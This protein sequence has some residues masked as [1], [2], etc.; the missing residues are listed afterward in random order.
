MLIKIG[1]KRLTGKRIT[2]F[3][4]AIDLRSPAGSGIKQV[5]IDYRDG[6]RPVT[7]PA[8]R[9]IFSHNFARKGTYSVRISATDGAGNAVVGYRKLVIK[10]P[11]KNKKG[12]KE[13]AEKRPAAEKPRKTPATNGR[14]TRRR[15]RR[16]RVTA[17]RPAS[18]PA[19]AALSRQERA[20][21]G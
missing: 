2:F 1:G 10:A 15:P 3:V 13:K 5:R 18:R 17:S 7:T 21:P 9:P 6:T 19:P 20:T 11:K 16:R 12:K 4:R 14:R 8:E